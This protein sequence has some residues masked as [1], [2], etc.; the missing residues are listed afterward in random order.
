V[1]VVFLLFLVVRG[2]VRGALARVSNAGQL[3]NFMGLVTAVFGLM[4]R[5]LAYIVRGMWHNFKSHRGG[6]DQES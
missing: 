2:L 5:Y 3:I 4:A 1:I 6:E